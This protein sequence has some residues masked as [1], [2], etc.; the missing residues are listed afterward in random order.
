[1][2][3]AVH[4]VHTEAV[5]NVVGRS[6]LMAACGVIAMLL[7][8]TRRSRWA[9]GA[10]AFALLSK[11]HALLAPV[12]VASL[13]FF[14][15]D[16]GRPE[17]RRAFPLYAGY[18]A[19]TVAWGVVVYALFHDA[20]FANVDPF[21]TAMSAPARW[22]TM[23]GVIPVWIRL[24]FFPADLSADYSP[25]V[26]RAWPDQIELAVLGALMLGA[27]I[28]LAI[29]MRQR[30]PP[31]LFAVI[32]LGV[33]MLPV[34]NIIVP[35]GVIVAERTLYLSSV[36]AVLLIAAAAVALSQTR[37]QAFLIPAAAALLIA[38]GV[39]TWTRNPVWRSNRDLLIS[40][41]ASHPGGSWTHAQL[42]RVYAANGGFEQATD[43]FRI[44]LA[45]FDA[46]PV[47]WSDG[48]N[49]AIKAKR[50]ALADS[51][52]VEAERAVPNNYLVKVAHAHAAFESARF[53]ESLEAARV[54]IALAPD[55]VLPRFFAGLAWTG[56]RA[57]DSAS[58]EFSRVPRGHPLRA[59]TDSVLKNLR[60]K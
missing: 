12:L 8:H 9:I 31:V 57:P 14:E 58:A 36:G 50:Y 39:R 44:S 52:V 16:P 37:Y 17:A 34:A 10:F 29:R 15:R 27:L 32:L 47:T 4:P 60:A 25:Q 59:L 53:A 51:M 23:L 6:E 45:L 18:A 42:A 46:N 3:F 30:N 40:T 28:I 24:W 20:R 43:E 21:W 13:D 35:T 33:T 56:L 38:G 54:A 1:V 48:I 41:V 11:E 26:T 22:L 2:L 19:V 49:A 55:S 5:A 7:L